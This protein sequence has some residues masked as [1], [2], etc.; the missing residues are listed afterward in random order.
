MNLC[1]DYTVH[2][3][4][5]PLKSTNIYKRLG[6]M[7]LRSTDYGFQKTCRN[8]KKNINTRSPG[9]QGPSPR[10]RGHH[11]PLHFRAGSPHGA[12]PLGGGVIIGPSPSGR[13]HQGRT[14]GSVRPQSVHYCPAQHLL[15]TVQHLKWLV[16]S[17][18]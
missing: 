18:F 16:M 4:M 9:H 15:H 8:Q 6:L 10:G 7:G 1:E 13:G 5:H 3:Y 12:P 11:W 17:Y 2:F 14:T